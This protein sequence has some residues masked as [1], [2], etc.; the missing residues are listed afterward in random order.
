MISA[1]TN[2]PAT[3]RAVTGVQLAQG[4]GHQPA[5]GFWA[6]AWS[7]VL[8]RPVAVLSIGWIALVAF[9]AV[10][11]PVLASGH[12]WYLKNADGSVSSPLIASL[13]SSDVTILAWTVIA[14]LVVLLARGMAVG[15]RLR[16]VTA[17]GLQGG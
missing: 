2:T 10:F 14:T 9:F 5:R 8:R 15:D 13:K 16:L 3:P 12:P 1:N 4:I 6:D 7:H 11:A 17:I